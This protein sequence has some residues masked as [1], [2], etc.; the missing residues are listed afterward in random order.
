[1]R[2]AAAT[3]ATFA[4]V[5][6]MKSVVAALAAVAGTLAAENT[7]AVAAAA[8][9]PAPVSASRVG[10]VVVAVVLTQ[11]LQIACLGQCPV[12]EML[13]LWLLLG[14]LAMAL[15]LVGQALQKRVGRASK[16]PS[17]GR[18]TQLRD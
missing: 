17:Q 4:A 3:P 11:V 10:M 14:E 18:N 1:M 7:P 5:P 8:K 6:T 15:V 12:A 13:L 16:R 9:L 2:V